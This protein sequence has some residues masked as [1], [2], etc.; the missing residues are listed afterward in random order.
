MA[1]EYVPVFDVIE[2]SGNWICPADGY[3]LI[4]CVAGGESG[5]IITITVD[6]SGIPS[7]TSNRNPGGTTSFGNY[8][9]A[10]GKMNNMY[11][12]ETAQ[13]GYVPFL[14]YAAPVGGFNSNNGT[15]TGYGAGGGK[16]SNGSSGAA[17][18]V[19]FCTIYIAKGTVIPCIIGNGG[20][21]V[22][23]Y[24]SPNYVI[25]GRPGAKGCIVIQSA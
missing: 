23:T 12:N 21:W 17:G 6:T 1:T 3:Y 13:G 25:E 4:T 14:G 19:C 24:Y 5:G 20:D 18:K 22:V 11:I 16:A 10:S 15:G 8:L 2:E 9:T 7:Y